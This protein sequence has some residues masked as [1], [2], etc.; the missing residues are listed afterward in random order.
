MLFS[1]FMTDLFFYREFSW[2]KS[3][4]YRDDI[5][6]TG[7]FYYLGPNELGAF[8]G[9]YGVFVFALLV[10][11]RRNLEKIMLGILFLF[12][13]YCLMHTFSRAAYFAFPLGILLII[14]F[15]NKKWLVLSIILLVFVLIFP[16]R[17]LPV[18]VVDRINMTTAPEQKQGEEET[19]DRSTETRFEFTEKGFDL[20]Q[21]SPIL[22]TGF[23]TYSLIV[24][25]DTHNNYMKVLSESGIIGF[26]LYVLLYLMS[27]KMGWK[28]YKTS[29]DQ[30]MKGLGMGFIACV[31][32]NM[33][34]NIPHD[35]WSYLNL[36]GFYWVILGLVVRSIIIV[37]GQKSTV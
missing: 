11:V 13:F 27:I 32:T 30:F 15:R 28:L 2:Y 16:Y 3:Y 17:F 4:H 9:Q 25:R 20:F 37:E 29:K 35:C 36:M 23:R 24:G 26:A 1:I 12:T 5:R 34:V 18:S 22:G 31:V 8:F 6:V 19:Y 21:E 7:T 14:F 33:V 10:F